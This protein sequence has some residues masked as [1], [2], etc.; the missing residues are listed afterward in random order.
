M[1]LTLSPYLSRNVIVAFGFNAGANSASRPFTLL[2]CP[3]S[4]ISILYC[5]WLMPKSSLYA[6]ILAKRRK[7]EEAEKQRQEEADRIQREKD[8]WDQF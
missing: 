8:F 7:Q 4:T 5:C 2:N 3:A 1:F 6:L